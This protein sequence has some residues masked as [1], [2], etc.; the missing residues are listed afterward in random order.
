MYTQQ[1][2]KYLM[3]QFDRRNIS[4]EF[5]DETLTFKLDNRGSIILIGT[6]RSFL[7]VDNPSLKELDMSSILVGNVVF[8]KKTLNRN[9]LL[10]CINKNN[11]NIFDNY[12]DLTTVYYQLDYEVKTIRAERVKFNEDS[13]QTEV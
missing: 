1:D 7:I 9:Y 13:T 6:D 10:F 8:N 3:E 12:N 5:K 4:Y 11:K 2:I